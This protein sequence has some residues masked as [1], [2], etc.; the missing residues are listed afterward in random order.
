[1]ERALRIVLAKTKV[2]R[3]PE[4]RSNTM[5]AIKGRGNRT[6]ETSIRLA[7]VRA[8]IFGWTLH[9]R[10]LLG[11]PDFYFRKERLA[12]FIDG[13]FWHGCP[14]CGYKPRTNAT[15]WSTKLRLNRARDRRVTRGLKAQGMIV[16]RIWEHEVK[17]NIAGCVKR[18]RR[19]IRTEP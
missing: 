17:G 10:T 6:T 13:C 18:I 5:R 7:L 14:R 1:M 12:L 11:C 4:V 8:G 3:V 2:G 15:F 16:L 9:D 19:A